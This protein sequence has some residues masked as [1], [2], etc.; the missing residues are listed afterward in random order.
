ARMANSQEAT[1]AR[2]RSDRDCKDHERTST[3]ADRD[4]GAAMDR[5]REGSLPRE[6]DSVRAGRTA[7]GGDQRYAP[8][9]DG[10]LERA[11]RGLRRR[12]R[13]RRMGGDPLP[14]RATGPATVA[15]PRRPR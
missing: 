14:R 11:D 10:P 6:E 1:D 15:H 5:S 3:R 7:A 8:G 13:P 2:V 4:P 12:A 9:M